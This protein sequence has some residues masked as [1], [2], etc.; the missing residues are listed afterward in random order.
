VTIV[1]IDYGES[2][3]I[4]KTEGALPAGSDAWVDGFD[5]SAWTEI[6]PFFITAYKGGLNL[7]DVPVVEDTI[8]F[9]YRPHSRDAVASAD[10]LPAPTGAPWPDDNLQALLFLTS[11]GTLV[12]TSGS[13][14]QSFSV[15]AGFNEITYEGFSEGQQQ[16]ELVRDGVVVACGTGSVPI[17]N[18]IEV[19]NFNA[20]VAQAVPGGCS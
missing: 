2:H 8:V 20:A 6:I 3:Y 16:V 11:P 15:L 10:P 1:N 4:Y 17:N 18:D 14:S 12:I 5:H 19:Y 7:S 9:Y 13:N